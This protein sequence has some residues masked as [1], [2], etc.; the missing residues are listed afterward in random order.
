MLCALPDGV[1]H[2][3]ERRNAAKHV[4]DGHLVV[5]RYGHPQP[6]TADVAAERVERDGHDEIERRYDDVNPLDG[7]LDDCALRRILHGSE[8]HAAGRVVWATG[9]SHAR[10]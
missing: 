1:D 6:L 4:A 2:L 7:R 5:V 3:F 9:M 10:R 8:E